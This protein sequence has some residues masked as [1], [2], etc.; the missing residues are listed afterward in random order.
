MK[1]KT[2][3]ALE[4]PI[5]EAL[6]KARKAASG[7]IKA[8][9]L[10]VGA[11]PTGL[12]CA[13]EAQK[14][15]ARVVVV[16]K[17]CI[18]NSLYHYPPHMVFFTTPE[19]LEIGN[20]PFTTAR[21]KPT[22]EEAL[23]YYRN[24]AR[25]YRLKVCQYERVIEVSGKDND[26]R[27]RSLDPHGV[28]HQYKVRK[29]IISTGYYDLPNMMNIPGEDLP[30]VFHYYRESHPYYDT[31]VLVI[32][33]KN[34]AALAALD[35]W[36]HGARVTLVHRNAGLHA[37]IKYWI[38]PDIENRIKNGEVAAFFE[39]SVSKIGPDFVRLHTPKGELELKN[40]FVFALTGYHP[41]FTFLES[42]GIELLGDHR[43]PACDPQTLETN[44]AGIYIAGV[45][46]AGV[47]TSEIFIENGRF[48]GQHIA[49]DLRKKLRLASSN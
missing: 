29:V 45:V 32:G 25:H 5:P 27:V 41:D 13:I 31:D 21:Q 39:S 34:S 46:L 40:D 15:G 1:T 37:N 19:L 47:R 17:G 7:A 48:H 12:A 22:R 26:F 42:M 3:P 10:V 6:V 11:G 38:L 28:E 35:L 33:G 20:I 43:R 49:Q 18:V 24:V 14:V 36:R 8:D 4:A 30:K 9:V 2:L 23:E 16:D 44:V